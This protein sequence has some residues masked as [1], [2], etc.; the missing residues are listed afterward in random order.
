MSS[1]ILKTNKTKQNKQQQQQILS[2]KSFSE[3]QNGH[4]RRIKG[5]EQ[6]VFVAF[7]VLE[8]VEGKQADALVRLFFRG[9]KKRANK[10]EQKKKK[11]KKK[12][13]ECII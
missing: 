5:L 8:S 6:Q 7:D 2:D 9:K 3:L 1:H 10:N 12:K 11:N 4:G 13:L